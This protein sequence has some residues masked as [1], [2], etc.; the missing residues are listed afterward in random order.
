[1]LKK[2]EFWAGCFFLLLGIG[3]IVGALRLPLG[4]PLDPKPGFFPLV[5]GIFLS[6]LSVFYLLRVLLKTGAGSRASGIAWRPGLLIIGLF[7]Y[8]LVLDSLG[9]V[10]AMIVLSVIILRI[11]ETKTGWKLA[12]VS[13]AASIGSYLLFDRILGVSLPPGILR[14][15]W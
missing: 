7:I 8:S 14:G 6:C 2:G 3:E 15:L 11:L 4:T 5:A 1:M 12:A 10:I 9:Y 13:L